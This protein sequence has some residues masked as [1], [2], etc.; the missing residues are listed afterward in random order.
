MLPHARIRQGVSDNKGC[1]SSG[2]SFCCQLAHPLS[3]PQSQMPC[4]ACL[5]GLCGGVLG[6][7]RLRWLVGELFNRGLFSN[8]GHGCGFPQKTRDRAS[9]TGS[10]S[11]GRPR[12]VS[13]TAMAHAFARLCTSFTSML[14]VSI[15]CYSTLTHLGVLRAHSRRGITQGISRGS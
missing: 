4:L 3:G 15:I 11:R 2:W 14:L 1:G 9:R 5:E 10:N 13:A 8:K 12:R 6:G 7:R